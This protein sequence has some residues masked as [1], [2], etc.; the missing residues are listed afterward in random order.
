MRKRERGK[1]REKKLKLEQERDVRETARV[2]AS[3]S[4][5]GSLLPAGYSSHRGL[6]LGTGGTRVKRAGPRGGAGAGPRGGPRLLLRLATRFAEAALRV[7]ASPAP[8]LL[9]RSSGPAR[10][11]T[12]APARRG[13]GPRQLL[14][15]HGSPGG[16]PWWVPAAPP[17]RPGEPLPPPPA[18]AA[19]AAAASSASRTQYQRR[20]AIKPG[21]RCRRTREPHV[22]AEGRQRCAWMVFVRAHA[23]ARTRAHMHHALTSTHKHAQ[24]HAHAQARTRTISFADI[25]RYHTPDARCRVLARI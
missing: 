24:A 17:P 4:V 13:S 11:V 12:A 16:K 1:G 20:G 25:I 19:A 18:A 10:W 14:P 3:V 23:R 6:V 9:S 5:G 8:P 15:H 21:Q 22:N 7:A 2:R